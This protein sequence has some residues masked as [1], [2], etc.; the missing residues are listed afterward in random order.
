M[1]SKIII[2]F[3]NQ[4]LGALITLAIISGC[5]YGQ[6]GAKYFN[7]FQK[8]LYTTKNLDSALI[9]IRALANLNPLQMR[10]LIHESFVQSFIDENLKKENSFQRKI[11]DSLLSDAN[12]EISV[13]VLPISFLVKA[14][15]KIKYPA[16]LIKLTESYRKTV[17]QESL[18]DKNNAELYGLILYQMLAK[19]NGNLPE[20]DSLINKIINN[21]SLAYEKQKPKSNENK[22][23][24]LRY[25]L[26][27]SHYLLAVKSEKENNL[28]Q[29]RSHYKSA[30]EFSPDEK[31]KNSSNAYFYEMNFLS[32]ENPISDFSRYYLQIIK[33]NG[34]KEEALKIM[35]S[36]AV[37]DPEFIPELREY[38]ERNSK[39]N[40]SF[41]EF[42][43]KELN[44]R[45]DTAPPINLVKLDGSR[46]TSNDY[47]GKWILIDFW[48]TWCTPCI[49]EMPKLQSFWNDASK[50]YNNEFVLLTVACRNTESEV[51]SFMLKNEYS[52]PAALAGDKIEKDYGIKSYPSKI[53]ITPQGKYLRIPW[54]EK[55]VDSIFLYTGL[56]K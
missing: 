44:S 45:I 21:L 15:D 25:L 47:L 53:L 6:S 8:H 31:D 46:F 4:V 24:W 14:D 51:K 22:R 34:E 38:F 35:C 39:S 19:T 2:L 48:G 29:A 18:L 26:S 56:K 30:Y 9:N 40:S 36:M 17:L 13:S 37:A 52:F 10:S 1:N 7:E 41:A 27:Y 16:E 42:W 50:L 49:K 3:R 12:K 5:L 43:N 11:L 23:A 55:W 54:N 33:Q 20:A 28:A 32:P